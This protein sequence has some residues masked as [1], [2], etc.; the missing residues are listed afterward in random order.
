[1]CA[2]MQTVEISGPN[3]L[4]SAK[5]IELNPAFHLEVLP[6]RDSLQY[7]NDYKLS[8]A[9]TLF[10][11]TLRYAGFSA[12]VDNLTQLG[13]LS[14]DRLIDL[15]TYHYWAALTSSLLAMPSTAPSAASLESGI[16]SRLNTLAA[17]TYSRSPSLAQDNIERTISAAR[18]LGLLSGAEPVSASPVAPKTADGRVSVL[19]A[20]CHLLERRLAY[21]GEERDVVIL[22]HTFGIRWPTGQQE[23]RHST[24]ISYG[25]DGGK[26][27]RKGGPYHP[28][29]SGILPDALAREL[30]S[31][32]LSDALSASSLSVS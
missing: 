29:R 16:R 20:F 2:C 7:A 22:H 8:G 21:T 3:L 9:A 10:R 6:N 1:M 30:M 12:I 11:G 23:K 25:G 15:N 26:T 14:N 13:L 5:P 31:D 4:S 17:S 24:L 18:W 19:D 32:D 27:G 28:F